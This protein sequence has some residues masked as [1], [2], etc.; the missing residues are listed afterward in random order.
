MYVIGTCTSHKTLVVKRT[1]HSCAYL[2]KF[3]VKTHKNSVNNA[4]MLVSY[5]HENI[6]T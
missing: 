2:C 6:V 1:I 3:Q 4:I 5:F